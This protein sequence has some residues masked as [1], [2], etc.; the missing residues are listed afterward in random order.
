MGTL[1]ESQTQA[2]VDTAA[3]RDAGTYEWWTALSFGEGDLAQ[4]PDPIV[5]AEARVDELELRLY[6]L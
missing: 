2:V 1:K 5:D 4:E 6:S 3:T